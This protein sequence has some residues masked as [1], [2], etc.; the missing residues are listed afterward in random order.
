MIKKKFL[1][2]GGGGGG[3]GGREDSAAMNFFNKSIFLIFRLRYFVMAPLTHATIV[4]K[5]K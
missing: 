4:A 1:F 5:A 3:G 2:L